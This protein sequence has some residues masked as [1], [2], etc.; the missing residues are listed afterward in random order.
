MHFYNFIGGKKKDYVVIFF[1]F[2]S[3][4]YMQ[5]KRNFRFLHSFLMAKAK[6][7]DKA[8]ALKKG[9]GKVKAGTQCSQEE[10]HG[11]VLRYF[12][13]AVKLT[14]GFSQLYPIAQH[15]DA[16]VKCVQNLIF[17]AVFIY[18]RLH[19]GA[20]ADTVKIYVVPCLKSL[21]AARA[22]FFYCV[23]V[24]TWHFP[25]GNLTVNVFDLA[26]NPICREKLTYPP[27]VP[28]TPSETRGHK[29]C[30]Q[31]ASK[32]DRAH[33][34]RRN[35]RTHGYCSLPCSQ[36]QLAAGLCPT[37]QETP[38][39]TL[40][41]YLPARGPR[42]NVD[43]VRN[44]DYGQ[45]YLTF[46]KDNKSFVHAP[47]CLSGG[48]QEEFGERRDE[49]VIGFLIV[50]QSC[51]ARSD[52]HSHDLREEP[53]PGRPAVDG[54]SCKNGQ[55]LAA[56]PSSPLSQLMAVQGTLQ[57]A[58]TIS[59]IPAPSAR[60]LHFSQASFCSL[61]TKGHWK[62]IQ[63]R[64]GNYKLP[65]ALLP[66]LGRSVGNLKQCFPAA[67]HNPTM[68]GTKNQPRSNT[69][70]TIISPGQTTDPVCKWGVFQLC[71]SSLSFLASTKAGFLLDLFSLIAALHTDTPLLCASP[72]ISSTPLKST[73][74]SCTG[75][76]QQD[77]QTFIPASR[78]FRMAGTTSS[79]IL[80]QNRAA[81]YLIFNLLRAPGIR[82]SLSAAGDAELGKEILEISLLECSQAGSFLHSFWLTVRQ[83][84]LVFKNK[85]NMISV[86]LD[87]F[88]GFVTFS[89]GYLHFSRPEMHSLTKYLL[90]KIRLNFSCSYLCTSVLRLKHKEEPEDKKKWK[91]RKITGKMPP[92]P[93]PQEGAH[94]YSHNYSLSFDVPSGIGCPPHV[95]LQLLQCRGLPVQG[96]LPRQHP[97]PCMEQV[98]CHPPVLL[99]KRGLDSTREGKKV[100]AK[101]WKVLVQ[102][103]P[104]G[105]EEQAELREAAAC[106]AQPQALDE[107]ESKH[108]GNRP[109]WTRAKREGQM[110]GDQESLSDL[111]PQACYENAETWNNCYL[112]VSSEGRHPAGTPPPPTSPTVLQLVKLPAKGV[113]LVTGLSQPQTRI[114]PGGLFYTNESEATGSPCISGC[115]KSLRS[116]RAGNSFLRM[117]KGPDCF[118]KAVFHTLVLAKENFQ[119]DSE[120]SVDSVIWGH[121]R[122]SWSSGQLQKDTG[123]L[124]CVAC[125]L[126]NCKTASRWTETTYKKAEL[127]KLFEL[128]DTEGKEAAAMPSRPEVSS[129]AWTGKM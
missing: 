42:H 96:H 43:L 120:R 28:S 33:G 50:R 44:S 51:V 54:C 4:S 12:R 30:L 75:E 60:F 76:S 126:H 80:E 95:A 37:A 88:S 62:M 101:S 17:K 92:I 82:Q 61:S 124:R 14:L 19:S 103:P 32:N 118:S 119:T 56:S 57:A 7:K 45:N 107:G 116:K 20:A 89:G 72:E 125:C 115:E 113:C 121:P 9:L 122:D 27:V 38:H 36:L 34:K 83:F 99:P 11:S 109:S 47:L 41:P 85:T 79:K 90:N 2:C 23:L 58:H 22:G 55:E 46:H 106:Q 3:F 70:N 112:P 8:A 16:A 13:N 1:S 98:L 94:N 64:G 63:G 18:T 100:Q 77:W 97:L 128:K 78:H 10:L 40:H 81:G 49:A 35:S 127:S 52:H 21:P 114:S 102:Q 15:H 117:S 71:F 91:G 67:E 31:T 25:F 86:S 84:S 87:L 105:C 29:P 93:A 111:K 65:P 69:A 53:A 73:C 129:R 104:R 59:S 39:H 74:L 66:R 123:C 6:Q 48:R 110:W 68:S 26:R 108:Q 5:S 24:H